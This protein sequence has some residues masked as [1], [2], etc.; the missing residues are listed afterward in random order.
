M[1]EKTRKQ[2]VAY[3]RARGTDIERISAGMRAELA[4]LATEERAI[5]SLLDQLDGWPK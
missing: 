1:D 3:L 4:H 5:K 2:V